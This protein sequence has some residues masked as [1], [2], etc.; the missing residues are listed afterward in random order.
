MTNK[1]KTSGQTLIEFALLLPLLLLIVMGLF[2][3]GRGVFYF[4]VLNTAV[5]EGTRFAIVQPACEYRSD[6]ASCSGSY[7][8]TYPLSCVDAQSTANIET[9][10]HVMDRLFNI[11]DLQSSNITIDHLVS[12][13]DDL[14]VHIEIT[15]NYEPITP[16]ITLLGNVTLRA[17]SQMLMT[18]AARP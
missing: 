4:A 9:C 11:T 13:T 14:L 1:N 15:Y 12:G 2:D 3:V 8:D 6:P 5:R 7:L 16:G 18:P 17:N 10:N